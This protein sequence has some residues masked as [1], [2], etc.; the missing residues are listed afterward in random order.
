MYK[1]NIKRYASTAHDFEFLEPTRALAESMPMGGYRWRS[2]VDC[3]ES[4]SAGVS[5]AADASQPSFAG[6]SKLSVESLE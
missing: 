5:T 4:C 6:E 1:E 3:D 2:P